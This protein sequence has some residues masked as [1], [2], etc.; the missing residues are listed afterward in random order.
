MSVSFAVVSVTSS[1]ISVDRGNEKIKEEIEEIVEDDE[2]IKFHKMNIANEE[3]IKVINDNIGSEVDAIKI[4]VG[5]NFY[6]AI[7]VCLSNVQKHISPKI[8]MLGSQITNGILTESPVMIFKYKV[9]SDTKIEF[10]NLTHT[11]VISILE[12]KFFH[13]GVVLRDNNAVETYMYQQNM[14]DNVMYKY[15]IQYVED[16]YQTDD[17]ELGDMVFKIGYNKNSL[18]I[19]EKLSKIVGKNVNGDVF[20][21]LCYKQDHM[22]ESTFI[23]INKEQCLKILEIISSS[24]FDSSNYYTN[25]TPENSNEVSDK[26]TSQIVISPYTTIER[27]YNSIIV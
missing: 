17:I 3:F 9:L 26:D 22:K 2:I 12:D 5:N 4:F 10:D 15:G 18:H 8:N 21:S 24:K 1:Y 19:N 20:C 16:N 23:S 7:F 11:D 13:Y 14:L 25:M 27:M 6:Q